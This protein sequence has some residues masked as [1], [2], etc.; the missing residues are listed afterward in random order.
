M[1]DKQGITTAVVNIIGNLDKSVKQSID[2][3]TKSMKALKVAGIATATAIGAGVAGAT[4]YLLDLGNELDGAYDTIRIGTG[5]TGEALEGLQGD[6][7]KV[8]AS[9]PTSAESAGQAIADVNTRL[10]LSGEELQ[11]V[12]KRAILLSENLGQGDLTTV[13]EKSSRALQAWNV[14]SS[15]MGDKMDYLWKVSQSTGIGFN[16]LAEK[17]QKYGATFQSLGYDFESASTLIGQL[18]KNGA[19]VD[20]VLAG[21]RTSIGK[22]TAQGLSASEGFEQ[23]YY[24]IK[25]AKDE[26]EA[27]SIASEIF[28]TKNGALM[29]SAI[30]SGRIEVGALTA[31]LSK[32]GETIS[33][34]AWDTMDYAEKLQVMKNKM[35]VALAPLANSVFDSL[36]AL[37]PVAE[38]GMEILTGLIQKFGGALPSL[39]PII[40]SVA[41]KVVT[42]IGDL[43]PTIEAVGNGII[44]AV[45]GAIPFVKEAITSVMGLVQKLMPTIQSLMPTIIGTLQK[46]LPPVM[47]IAQ[48]VAKVINGILP[49]VS[50]L[51]DAIVPIVAGLVDT[52]API[53]G[54][55]IDVVMP[56]VDTVTSVI[57]P[58]LQ[59]VFGQITVHINYIKEVLTNVIGFIQNVFT[60]NWA[61]ALENVKNLALAPLNYI[62][63][64]FENIVSTVQKVISAVSEKFPTIGAVLQSVF[65]AVTPIIDSIKGIF[66][67][68]TDF[69]KN[70][71]TGNWRGAWEAVKSIFTNIFSGLAGIVK[72]PLNAVVGIVNKVISSINSV[73]FKIPDW[74]PVVGGKA[75]S[76]NIPQIPTFAQGGIATSPSICG[77][78]GFPEYVIST[79]PKY[80]GANLDLLAQAGNALNIGTVADG[81]SARAGTVNNTTNNEGGKVYK[82]EFAPVINC[83][84]N[85]NGNDIVEALKARLPEF[86]DMITGALEAEREGA[87]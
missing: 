52:I 40:S 28:G 18:V 86:V 55:I 22:L 36:N 56:V 87:Y 49:V 34:C 1:A 5:A 41:D 11:E 63:G 31:E 50:R 9:L 29:A 25:N 61:G 45:K 67:G 74:V 73:G 46:I 82:I 78:G 80:R 48:T 26:T 71:F 43:M 10:G 27:M 30:R 13:I 54:G 12:S 16:E 6:F 23:Y 62:R 42:F 47:K 64:L 85:A 20:S 68:L 33:G 69:I 72:A 2:K 35:K 81:L 4:K 39:V 58:I 76:L 59:G 21:M 77:E 7:E 66:N 32:S 53:I 24:N 17:T 60:G 19:D 38:K 57:L 79:D 65:N 51:V 37:M 8:F 3:A 83:S 44:S 75:F 14:D 15:E 84:G 70:V